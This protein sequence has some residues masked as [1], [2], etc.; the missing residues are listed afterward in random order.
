MDESSNRD[1]PEIELTDDMVAYVARMIRGEIKKV[2]ADH[3]QEHTRFCLE[4]QKRREER[5]G[6]MN[7]EQTATTGAA[8]PEATS[9]EAATRK[10]TKIKKDGPA[11]KQGPIGK[12]T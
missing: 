4:Q 1:P 7:K 5:D 3:P 12:I 6:E 2:M 11:K 8:S 9:P 10:K